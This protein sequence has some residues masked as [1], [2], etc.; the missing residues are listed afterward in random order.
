MSTVVRALENELFGNDFYANGLC[1]DLGTDS[2]LF[3]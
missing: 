1:P 3:G 2:V